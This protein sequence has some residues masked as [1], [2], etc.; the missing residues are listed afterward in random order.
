MGHSFN[1]CPESSWQLIPMRLVDPRIALGMSAAGALRLNRGEDDGEVELFGASS[2]G[3]QDPRPV[4]ALVLESIAVED[5]QYRL[6]FGAVRVGRS[7]GFGHDFLPVFRAA[8]AARS[9]HRVSRCREPVR[10][11]IP[12]QMQHPPE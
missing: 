8:G 12:D 3:I 6:G 4:M 1:P 5:M 10:V 9:G 2:G 7:S 11:G